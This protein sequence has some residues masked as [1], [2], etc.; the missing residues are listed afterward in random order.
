MVS[1]AKVQAGPAYTALMQ[2][3]VGAP[4]DPPWRIRLSPVGY[5]LSLWRLFRRVLGLPPTAPSA[6]LAG[7][8][9]ALKAES[10]AALKSP[11]TIVSVTAPWVAAW[12]DDIPVDST[13]NDALTSAGLEPWTWESTWP[14]YLGET[15]SVLAANGRQHCRTR[16]CGVPQNPVIWPNVTFFIRSVLLLR[17]SC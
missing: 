17:R 16:W 13:V 5:G 15:N 8:V 10:E 12:Q 11:I 6:V 4:L 14:I 2:R 7:L 1:L 9:A 3:M